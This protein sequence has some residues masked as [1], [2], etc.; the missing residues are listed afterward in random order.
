MESSIIKLCKSGKEGGLFRQVIY[1][2]FMKAIDNFYLQ[3]DEPT[4]S[5]KLPYLGIVEGQR[6][7]H[8]DLIIEK[9]SRM[10]IMLFE[11]NK[12]LPAATIKTILKQAIHLYKS[13]EIKI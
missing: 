7:S 11:P 3:L 10:K 2:A 9:R 6:L 5:C 8:P 1:L 13:G 4:Q 12:D